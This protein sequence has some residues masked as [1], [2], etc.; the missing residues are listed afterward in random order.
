MSEETMTGTPAGRRFRAALVQMRSGRDVET[1]VESAARLIREAAGG[2][3]QY[4]QTPEMTTLMEIDRE[5]LFADARLEAEDASLVG[6]RAL[7]QELGVW[8]HIGSMAVRHESGKL[9]N[10]AFLITPEGAVAA[11]YDKIHM[12]D[13]DLPNGES[14][15]E[16][17]SYEP[18]RTAVRVELPW[19]LLGLTICYDLRF[20]V[21]F[22]ALARAGAHFIAVPSAFTRLTG[23]AHWHTLLK[24]RA[25][26]SQCFVLAAAQGGLHEHG[27][28]TFG[29]SLIVSPWGDILA[30]GGTE[31]GV[32][33]ADI[34][35]SALD[36]VRRHMPCLTH[37]RP[38]EM[39]LAGEES[40]R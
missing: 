21:L 35:L 8:L 7:A 13:V 39:A 36:D 20:P 1:N 2:G 28:E 3:A 17:R 14:Y 22:R 10:R 27:R 19:G 34:D 23:Q 33:A 37:D 12:F 6:F 16:S 25:I 24:A 15:K 38:F 18:G 31:P 29:H 9:A 4:I 5:R 11:C 26:E 32:V 30:E 40:A